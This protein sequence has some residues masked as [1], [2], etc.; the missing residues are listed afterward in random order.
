MQ[1]TTLLMD[2]NDLMQACSQTLPKVC[3]TTSDPATGFEECC[4]CH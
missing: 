3:S 2:K 1:D 4:K